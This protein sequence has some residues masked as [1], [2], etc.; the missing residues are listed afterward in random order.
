MSFMDN[1]ND[2]LDEDLPAPP[3]RSNKEEKEI[4]TNNIDNN[5]IPLLFKL[6]EELNSEPTKIKSKSFFI[7]YFL[8][9]GLFLIGYY[10][11]HLGFG[12]IILFVFTIVLTYVVHLVK[13][14]Q[15]SLL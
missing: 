6:L 7:Y 3:R 10:L 11:I 12:H 2:I 15:L 9:L 8:G 14:G 4:N 1:L 5:F 13:R